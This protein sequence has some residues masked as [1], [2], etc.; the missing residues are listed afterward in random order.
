VPRIGAP[1]AEAASIDRLPDLG[2]AGRA[3]PAVLL[4][5]TL[6]GGVAGCQRIGLF[7]RCQGTRRV[8]EPQPAQAQQA[9]RRRMLRVLFS[10]AGKDRH[11][12]GPGAG[13]VTRFAETDGLAGVG[14]TRQIK[15]FRRL[16]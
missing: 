2:V 10:D 14:H 15:P 12:P 7:G 5:K 6:A 4:V 8:A 3:H 11:G 9:Q 13:L 16:G 1:A